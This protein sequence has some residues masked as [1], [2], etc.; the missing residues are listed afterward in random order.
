MM[1]IFFLFSIFNINKATLI[2]VSS[3]VD[4]LRVQ[5]IKAH[6]NWIVIAYA[7]FITCYRLKDS[8]GWQHVFTSPHI[9]CIIERVAINAKMGSGADG[10]MVAISY[11]SQVRLWGVSEEGIK[12]NVGTF[13][14]NVRV[15]YLFFIGSQLVALSPTGKI[16]VW[17]AMTHHWQIQDV[18]PILSFDTAGSFLLL[19]CNNGSIY[20]IGKQ[21]ENVTFLSKILSTFFDKLPIYI[22][23]KRKK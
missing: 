9:E 15:E 10:K 14:L 12:I 21:K 13:N 18:V 2:A 7:H 11:G 1:P 19:G 6:H 16:G 17:H 8:S 23:G 20:Y 4:P 5:I 22:L 3:W